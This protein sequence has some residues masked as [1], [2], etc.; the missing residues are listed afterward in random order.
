M[1]FSAA[2]LLK[3]LSVIKPSLADDD[4]ER[5]VVAVSW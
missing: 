3:V 4:D 2:I 1:K 5:A